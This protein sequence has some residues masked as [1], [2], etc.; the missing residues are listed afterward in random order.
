MPVKVGSSLL[1]SYLSAGRSFE[2]GSF[3]PLR[4]L[5]LSRKSGVGVRRR[6]DLPHQAADVAVLGEPVELPASPG[7]ALDQ[8]GEPH[9]LALAAQLP[10]VLAE[11]LDDA[12]GHLLGRDLQTLVEVDQL[13]LDSDQR[14]ADLVVVDQLV[15][16][17]DARQ[18]LVVESI[19]SVGQRQ[20]EG[21]ESDRA[22]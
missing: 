19:E 15:R 21:G 7:P 1:K 9:E 20:R 11:V 10:R 13:T 4:C 22:L 17:I 3:E 14:R 2:S 5:C 6:D 16:V 8:I 12:E 18:A